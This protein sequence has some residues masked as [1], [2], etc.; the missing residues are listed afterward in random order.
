MS[1]NSVTLHTPGD[2]KR[3]KPAPMTA[4]GYNQPSKPEIATTLASPAMGFMGDTLQQIINE[5]VEGEEDRA[6]L[7]AET[8]VAAEEEFA[9]AADRYRETPYLAQLAV[10]HR[11][12]ARN[13]RH[14]RPRHLAAYGISANHTWSAD[15]AGVNRKIVEL[16][17]K[18]DPIFAR[19]SGFVP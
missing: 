8:E 19:Q 12:R 5:G 11:A 14:W 10:T 9:A 15:A 18:N 1:T 13:A 4:D 6:Q 3:R 2:G 16:H 17:A 7:L